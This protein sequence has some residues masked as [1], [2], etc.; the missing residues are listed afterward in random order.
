MSTSPWVT[1]GTLRSSST[2]QSTS[3]S[4]ARW[5]PSSA[6][7]SPKLSVDGDILTA[8][9]H[10][11]PW[12][13][14]VVVV[15]RH[16]PPWGKSKVTTMAACLFV[17]GWFCV[18]ARLPCPALSAALECY[19]PQVKQSHRRPSEDHFILRA[20]D[21]RSSAVSGYYGL[22]RCTHITQWTTIPYVC[23]L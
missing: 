7:R 3:S 22:T 6:A 5:A 15:V 9:R 2:V 8:V 17:G 20:A 4:I 13:V 19:L 23:T 12:D 21:F 16:G 18:V 10:G 11:P 14:L 1:S